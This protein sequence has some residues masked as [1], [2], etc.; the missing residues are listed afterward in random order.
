MATTSKGLETEKE[1]INTEMQCPAQDEERPKDEI[2]HGSVKKSDPPI[3]HKAND[4]K[5]DTGENVP[6]HHKVDEEEGK[7]IRS[8]QT[9]CHIPAEDAKDVVKPKEGSLHKKP[10]RKANQTTNQH[11][12]IGRVE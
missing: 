1:Q 2:A 8:G 6:P 10:C 12:D 4:E 5:K 11:D 9:P 3:A 7:Y